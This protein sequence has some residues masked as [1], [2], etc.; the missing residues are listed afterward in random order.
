MPKCKECGET[1]T[2][3]DK[4]ICPYCGC[5]DPIDKDREETCDITQAISTFSSPKDANV[6]VKEHKKVVMIILCLLF[7]FL[8]LDC[9]YLG[10]K[11]EGLFR[12]L[13]S[14]LLFSGLF[15]LFFFLIFDMQFLFPLIIGLSAL[16]L[17]NIVF[18]LIVG[19]K[20]KKD[21]SGVFIR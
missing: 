16:L 8:G 12:I 13:A 4:E 3:F 7:G 2:K 19:I 9:F 21:A 10:F 15:V 11:K 20:R 6:K 14:V 18:S 17:E 1:I 5:K